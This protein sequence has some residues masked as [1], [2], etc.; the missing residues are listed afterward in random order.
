MIGR[1][2]YLQPMGIVL[3]TINDIVELQKGKLTFSDT[4]HGKIHFLIKMYAFKWEL[5]FSVMDIGN[6]RSQVQI[7][8]EGEA[9]GRENLIGREFALLDSMLVTGA[10]IE[11]TERQND[12][13]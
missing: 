3:D 9:R 13:Q 11:I 6:N 10:Q 8:I 1:K 4:P 7:E 12:E 2:I 5:R